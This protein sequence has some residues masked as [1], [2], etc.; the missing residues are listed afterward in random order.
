MKKSLIAF[1][2]LGM[3]TTALKAQEITAFP[4]TFGVEF[5]QDQDKL[6][7]KQVDALM[8][9]NAVSAEHWK[10]SKKNLLG[11]MVF[12]AIN[13][14]AGIWAISNEVNNKPLT[15]PMI[16]FGA[17]ALIG[18]IF[19]KAAMKNKKM[20]ILKYNDSLGKETSFYLVPAANQNGIG[21]A[22]KF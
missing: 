18:S 1:L 22:L 21:L 11:G 13:F 20:A 2:F 12:G 4:S 16:A 8:M 9:E 15:E 5:Y 17:S 7:W 3:F 6:S 14:G 19:G 10:K